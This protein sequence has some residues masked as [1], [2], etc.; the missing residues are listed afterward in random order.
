MAWERSNNPYC[1]RRRSIK[2]QTTSRFSL[3]QRFGLTAARPPLPV[4]AQ[5]LYPTAR[6]QMLR[7]LYFG[8]WAMRTHRLGLQLWPLYFGEDF[9]ANA[10]A[11]AAGEPSQFSRIGA[12]ADDISACGS[13]VERA[14]L[15]CVGP[16]PRAAAWKASRA[17]LRLVPRTRAARAAWPA[18][19]SAV[20]SFAAPF[21]HP[22]Q[23]RAAA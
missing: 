14:V 4:H 16:S 1:V 15:G 10:A 19:C 7:D 3:G 9:N 6:L 2:P 5:A 20:A 23:V 11:E 17:A 13:V 21:R 12:L 22:T 18:A 8:E